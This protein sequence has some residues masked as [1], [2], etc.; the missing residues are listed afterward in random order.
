MSQFEIEQPEKE[1]LPHSIWGIIS[2]WLAISSIVVYCAIFGCLMYVIATSPN[3]VT[4][5]PNP[6]H[7]DKSAPPLWL[8]GAGLGQ[9][10]CFFATFAAFILGIVGVCQPHT[11]KVFSY[12]GLVLSALP[13]LLVAAFMLIGIIAMMFGISP[14]GGCC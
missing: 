9:L 12:W 10:G 1:R 6:G 14:K 2:F 5:N 7:W 3:P 4:F 11:R 13:L 8:I